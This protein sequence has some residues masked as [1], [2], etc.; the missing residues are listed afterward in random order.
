MASA[1]WLAWLEALPL[2]QRLTLPDGARVLLVHASPGNDDDERI[3]PNRADAELQSVL[4]ESEADVVCVGHTHWVMD[5]RVNNIRLINPGSIS[6]PVSSDL[7]AKLEYQIITPGNHLVPF[8]SSTEQARCVIHKHAGGYELFLRHDLPEP[9]RQQILALPRETVFGDHTL[10]KSILAPCSG[11]WIG[12]SYVFARPPT[13]SQFP[14]VIRDEGVWAI[15]QDGA[16]VSWAWSVRENDRAAEVAVETAA[17]YRRRGYAR[18]VTLAWA[19][20]ILST[21]RVAFYCH[22]SDN[23]ASE[24]LAKSLGLVQYT[25]G[26]AYE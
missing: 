9:V 20:H 3:W 19:H 4:A 1:G 5:R 8:P 14:D 26:K 12:K 22:N 17:A 21:G 18:Q 11:M 15:E 2:E 24:A 6:N 7:S 25:D 10:I 16:R 23:A 13:P